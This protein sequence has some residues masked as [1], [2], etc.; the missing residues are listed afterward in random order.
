M[1]NGK[2]LDSSNTAEQPVDAR[3]PL[4]LRNR[5]PR[6]YPLLP[7]RVRRTR[8]LSSMVSRPSIPKPMLPFLDTLDAAPGFNGDISPCAKARAM[9]SLVPDDYKWGVR[10]L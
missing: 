6:V 4:Q 10:A 1:Y 8:T 7:W 3:T 2:T 9:R 5:K